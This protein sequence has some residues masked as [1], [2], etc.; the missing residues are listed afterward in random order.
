MPFLS[1]GKNLSVEKSALG[2]CVY[3]G[4]EVVRLQGSAAD[5]A[6]VNVRLCKKLSCVAC[7]HGAA[8]LNSD[9][10]CSLFAVEGLDGRTDDSANFVCLLCRG[11]LAGADGPNRL[12]SD[13]DALKL[14]FGYAA[15]G[16]L[17]LPGNELIGEALPAVPALPAGLT[18]TRGFAPLRLVTP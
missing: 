6:A 18:I 15:E 1:T 5:E 12:V 13:D 8:V 3:D 14:F 9:A 11:G 4:C 10:F 17:C 16:D 7:V 2:G